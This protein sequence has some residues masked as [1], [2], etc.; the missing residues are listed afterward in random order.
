LKKEFWYKGYATEFLKRFLDVWWSLPRENTPMRVQ[1]ISLGKYF[2]HQ[3]VKERLVAE[4]H[5]SNIGSRR[6]IEKA[7]FVFYGYLGAKQEYGYWVLIS[8][9]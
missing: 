2:Y 5:M 8:P 6:V 7:G 1:S 9:N 3:E 4:I